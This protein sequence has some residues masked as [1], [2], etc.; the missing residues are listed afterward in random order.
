MTKQLLI[1]DTQIIPKYQLKKKKTQT[2]HLKK[3][4]NKLKIEEEK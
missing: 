3:K 1:P 2:T 4:S